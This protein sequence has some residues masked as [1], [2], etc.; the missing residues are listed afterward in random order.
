MLSTLCVA[1]LLIH[2]TVSM[3]GGEHSL[4]TVEVDETRIPVKDG[5]HAEAASVQGVAHQAGGDDEAV[6]PLSGYVY[7]GPYDKVGAGQALRQ[8]RQSAYDAQATRGQEEKGDVSIGAELTHLPV[9]FPPPPQIGGA[10]ATAATVYTE[11]AQERG[12]GPPASG[13]AET[14]HAEAD[15][16]GNAVVPPSAM[17]V[18][19]V[20]GEANEKA[21]VPWITLAESIF[22]SAG[23]YS[24]I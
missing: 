19:S 13:T 14:D 24:L 4:E 22:A 15:P 6:Q 9:A 21:A 16:S 1:S 3:F 17:Q 10:A 20:A 12:E 18:E 23:L 11:D 7:N 2:S 5:D 8:P